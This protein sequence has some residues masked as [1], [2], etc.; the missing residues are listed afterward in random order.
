VAHISH[1]N[2]QQTLSRLRTRIATIFDES[3]VELP[4]LADFPGYNVFD[5]KKRF[6][7]TINRQ[8]EPDAAYR[9]LVGAEGERVAE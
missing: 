1:E 5:L 9:S 3:P 2:R 4:R 6:A 8:T 7:V